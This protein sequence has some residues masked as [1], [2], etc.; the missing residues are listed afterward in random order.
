[1][2]TNPMTSPG[3]NHASR[4]NVALFGEV[5]KACPAALNNE[6]TS[7]PIALGADVVLGGNVLDPGR[8]KNRVRRRSL[9]T[10]QKARGQ[11]GNRC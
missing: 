9:K 11:G 6:Q 7:S 4:T 2:V 8:G 10:H 3:T 1:M 5:V